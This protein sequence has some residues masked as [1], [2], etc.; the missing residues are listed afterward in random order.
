MIDLHTHS[1]VSDGTDSPRELVALAA[2]VP[3]TALAVTDHDT[4]E[5]VEEA[6]AAGVE[7]GVRVVPACE[8]SCTV[9]P[10]VGAMHLLVYF[11]NLAGPLSPR[12]RDLQHARSTRNELI[13]ARLRHAGIDVTLDEVLAE[14]G[15]GVVGRPHIAA[16]LVRKGVAASIDEAFERWL[17]KGRPAYVERTRLG[18]EEAI[19]LA[20]RSA[21]VTS[22][23]HPGTLELSADGLEQFVERLAATGLDGVECDY[24]RYSSD[25][26]EALRALAGRHGL[27]ATGG[28]DYH[29]HNKPGLAVGVGYG[30]LTV[31]D[32]ALAA[33]ESRRPPNA[34]GIASQ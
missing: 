9:P 11:P 33:L 5:H 34:L 12:L 16:V 29:G 14:A 1:T 8:L 30:D 27:V 24:A 4:L 26:R 19:D 2:A 10:G 22:L 6:T 7:H 32:D 18:P 13:V 17:S 20:H 15:A 28:S 3:L 25:E 31:P 21:A 23:A